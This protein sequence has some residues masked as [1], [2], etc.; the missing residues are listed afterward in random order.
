MSPLPKR[1]LERLQKFGSGDVYHVVSQ[2]QREYNQLYEILNSIIEGVVVSDEEHYLIMYNRPAQLFL[3]MRK[4]RERVKIWDCIDDPHIAKYIREVLIDNHSE[5]ARQFTLNSRAVSRTFQCH[6]LPLVRKGAII[7]NILRVEE[8]TERLKREAKLYHAEKLASLTTLTANVAHEIKNPLGSIAIYIQLI[9]KALNKPE[10]DRAQIFHNIE[11]ITEEIDR[12]NS[13]ILD[14]LFAVRPMSLKKQPRHIN[15]IVKELVTF[16]QAELVQHSIRATT[17]LTLRVPPV[18]VDDHYI[19]EVIHNIVTN[20]IDA[21][22]EGGTLSFITSI[23]DNMV[24]LEIRDTGIGM[25]D[26]TCKRVFE[27]YFTTKEKGS[28][29]GM[30]QSYKIIQAHDGNIDITSRQGRGT[31]CKIYLP[32]SHSTQR[33]LEN[34]G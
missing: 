24:V 17:Q 25:N 9:K 8:I 11:I 10:I 27:P 21:M 15:D 28:G 18:D 13:V 3:P 22:P 2:I 23:S 26:S 31:T 34:I 7:G 19:K 16:Y 4:K 1:A 14:F 29:I 5:V 12:L 32:F 20:A 6:I 33:V 30:T